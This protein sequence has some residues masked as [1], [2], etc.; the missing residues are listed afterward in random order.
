[1]EGLLGLLEEVSG[2]PRRRPVDPLGPY[3]KAVLESKPLAYWRLSE[4]AGPRAADASA[5]AN[6]G[7]YEPGV[8]FHL[9]G[10]QSPGLAAAGHE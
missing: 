3:A 10:P 1:M 2:R 4:L 9:E 7:Q 5:Q 8:A 6:H